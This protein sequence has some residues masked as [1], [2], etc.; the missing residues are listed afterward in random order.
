LDG[1]LERVKKLVPPSSEIN[2][3]DVVEL[4]WEVIQKIGSEVG[5][6]TTREIVHISNY[7]AILPA[8]LVEV[9]NVRL[10]DFSN[11]LVTDD[12][13]TVDLSKSIPFVDI[14]GRSKQPSTTNY[15]L[16]YKK[17]DKQL[18]T[19]VQI[20]NIIVDCKSIPLDEYAEPTIV[21]E[22]Y[23]IDAVV[24][25]VVKN[26]MWRAMMRNPAKYQ[27]IFQVADRNSQ[28][29]MRAANAKQ[30]IGTEDSLRGMRNKYLKL[31]PDLHSRQ[32]NIYQ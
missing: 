31:L 10:I 21:E 26:M 6:V 9:H 30:H 32:T 24:W 3:E 7:V 13:H 4:V 5:Y 28:F 29:Y 25:Y 11:E 19:N 16:Q 23:Y 15:E 17:E 14:S 22:P 2:R 27:S 12:I 20:G 8:W 1:L 18:R